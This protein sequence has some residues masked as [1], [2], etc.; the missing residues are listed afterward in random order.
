MFTIMFSVRV[1]SSC[2][3]HSFC[4]AVAGLQQGFEVCESA[5]DH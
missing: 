3:M 1:R 4:V 2:L 5:A